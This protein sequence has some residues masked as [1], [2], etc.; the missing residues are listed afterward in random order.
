LKH[1]H[2]DRLDKEAVQYKPNNDDRQGNG[3]YLL[4]RIKVFQFF[5]CPPQAD[6]KI[7]CRFLAKE[8]AKNQS[9]LSSPKAV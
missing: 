6:N 5:P 3:K 2:D 8:S 9:V 1:L 4:I 7:F